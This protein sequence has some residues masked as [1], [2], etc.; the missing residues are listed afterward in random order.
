MRADGRAVRSRSN[1]E[2]AMKTPHLSVS[3]PALRQPDWYAK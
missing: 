2:P 3:L 1:R